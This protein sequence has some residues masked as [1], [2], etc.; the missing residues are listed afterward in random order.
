M[1]F[2]VILFT[3]RAFEVLPVVSFVYTQMFPIHCLVFLAA[4]IMSATISFKNLKNAITA[5]AFVF[6]LTGVVVA[7]LHGG[8]YKLLFRAAIHLFA[9]LFL[10][11]YELYRKDNCFLEACAW[12]F[13]VIILIN[14][15]ILVLKP[16]GI[17]TMETYSAD[18][19]FRQIDRM[20]FLEVDNRLSLPSLLA[21]ATAY[22]LP[23][24]KINKI[25]RITAL[26]AGGFTNLLTMSGTGIGSYFVMLIYVL[27]IHKTKVR[28]KLIN[29]KTLLVAYVFCMF[30]I[31][32]AGLIPPLAHIIREVLHKD[33]T[34]SGR[35]YIWESC[36]K[37]ISRHPIIGY[38]NFDN[39]WIITWNGIN[40]NAHNL[41]FDILIQGG[42]VLLLGYL[43]M[44]FTILKTV[45]GNKD[46]KS[47]LLLVLLFCFFV[48]MLCE[49]FIDNNYIFLAYSLALLCK[50]NNS[51]KDKLIERLKN[52]LKFKA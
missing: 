22:L 45:S 51:R 8:D 29:V 11:S 28:E 14:L 36:L 9:I 21:I 52:R 35:T 49:S 6:I 41:F 46:K 50:Y 1:F 5:G 18:G 31:V 7:V 39:G 26:A 40:R 32:Y 10:V 44:V 24:K 25:L 27:F 42:F 15:V 20:N 2:L 30:L 33:L 4:I 37:M 47:G 48:V 16:E 43:A 13:T 12:Y 19:Q 23:D 38:G 34:F 3:P 17:S